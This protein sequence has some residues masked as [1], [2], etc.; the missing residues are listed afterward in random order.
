MAFFQQ[1]FREI[2]PISIDLLSSVAPL[3]V[4]LTN[5]Y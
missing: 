5:L 4:M 1:V 2:E 3:D